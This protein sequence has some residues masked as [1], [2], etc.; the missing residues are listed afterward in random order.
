MQ[1][2]ATQQKIEQLDKV[3]DTQQITQCINQFLTAYF[4]FERVQAPV[5]SYQKYLTQDFQETIL[6]E[7]SFDESETQ[8]QT[9]GNARF[10]SNQCYVKEVGETIQTINYVCYTVDLLTIDG[11]VVTSGMEVK[12]SVYLELLYEDGQYWINEKQFLSEKEELL[13]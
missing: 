7:L 6:Q 2:N 4:T 12:T 8:P 3:S 13:W 11:E 5:E 9:F 1:K 10:L